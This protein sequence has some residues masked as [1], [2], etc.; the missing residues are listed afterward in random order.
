MTS[1]LS[2]L[3]NL[4]EHDFSAALNDNLFKIDDVAR[5]GL[6]GCPTTL[7]FDPV[8]SLL[9][10][11]TANGNVHVL[12]QENVE[13]VFSPGNS[14]TSINHVQIIRSLY[15]VTVDS[16]NYVTVIS[17][18]TKETLS[19]YHVTGNVTAVTSDPSLDWLFL[20][21][22]NGQVVIYDVDRGN[23]APYR[24][25]NLQ[26]SVFSKFRMSPV[27]SMALHP[28]DTA[29]LLVCY[30][31]VVVVFSIAKSEIALS[32]RY[33]VPPGAPGGDTNPADI[34][35]Y[36]YPQVVT[37]TWHPNGHH[38]LTAHVDGSLVFWD[39]T[40]GSLL[41]ARTLIDTD[42][43]IPR[44]S[45]AGMD[46]PG[47]EGRNPITDVLW[48]CTT[49]PEETSVL[50]SGGDA[51]QGAVKGLTMLDFGNTPSVAIT[52]YQLM[53]Q[54]Y[55]SPRK[56]K[57]FPLPE[58]VDASKILMLPLENPFYAGNF[59]PKY[60]LA[61][62]S[63]GE[64]VTMG[65]PNGNIITDP[66][67]VPPALGW[68]TPF[69]TSFAMSLVPRNQWVGMMASVHGS[70][71][72]FRGGA[73][74]RRHLRSFQSRTALCTGHRDGTVKLWDA[75]HG[76]IEDAKAMEVSM[77]NALRQHSGIAV[78]RISFAGSVAELA[79][80][81]ENGE[82]ALFSFGKRKGGV[83]I[84]SAMNS[85][86]LD[87]APIVVKDI[88]DRAPM[89]IKEGFMPQTMIS[90]RAGPVTA[91]THSEIGF[92]AI[93]YANGEIAVID[94]RGPACIF[95]SQL[96]PPTSTFS[97][98]GKSRG[99]SVGGSGPECATV[100][101][102]G[103]H[104]LGDDSYSSIVLTVGSSAGYVYTYRILPSQRGG[105]E[106][107]HVG[108]FSVSSEPIIYLTPINAEMGVS[109]I[110]NMDTL[111]KLG[112]GIQIPGAL[113]ALTRSEGRVIRQPDS[114]VT[115]K[116]F[117]FNCASAG[118]SYL[119]EGDSLALVC[120]TETSELRILSVPAMREISTR[121]LPYVCKNG[122]ARQSLV[123][124]NGDVI[125][126]PDQTAGAMIKIWGKGIRFDDIPQDALY[127][128]MK[129]V[130]QRPTISTMQWV[131]GRQYISAEDLDELIGG[132]RRPKSK[133]QIEQEKAKAEQ[134]RL[135]RK[136][137]RTSTNSSENSF[138]SMQRGVEERG[139]KL[140][141]VQNALDS[142]EQTS[143][144]YMNSL[145]DVIKDAKSSAIKSSLKSKFFG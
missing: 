103:I 86:S 96:Q 32:L 113:L 126:R 34:N 23:L 2:K 89:N 58:G 104:A 36:R 145:N 129:V 43:N 53:G 68:I 93:G 42:V 29:T 20:G 101:E 94:R 45:T 136:Q 97:R 59:D 122:Y 84:S 95:M 78:T 49:N 31:D 1:V 90:T 22:E 70:G 138:N 67:V 76:E 91:L 80:A 105:Y 7:T 3:K 115:H 19:Q 111:G 110:A 82:V 132:P 62:L 81:C 55:G 127:D 112:Q 69:I 123:T 10:I 12:G 40:E 27:L 47:G 50:V 141:N 109:A 52:S 102:F 33:E 114:R 142:L 107:Q 64:L 5:Y 13:V 38:I 65:Y 119:R 35:Q 133:A 57:I 128:V 79:V 85:M 98:K 88:R 130:P 116:R 41:Q 28:R 131:R 75:S 63:S 16:K 118:I 51:F 72:M 11:G 6:S 8:Q 9:A 54:H 137:G 26:K 56:Q 66:T 106:V 140:G 108:C 44:R 46:M 39:A 71:G 92:V 99:G 37:A 120:V 30:N 15:L 125:L 83:G 139:Y 134:E 87:D 124:L 61:L 48:C 77:E 14:E 4:G 25:G 74:A 121:M 17:L 73:P 18:D 60:L 117:N 24:I 100:I 21:L 143:A 144:E 135:L